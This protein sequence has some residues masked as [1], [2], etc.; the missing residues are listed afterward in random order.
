MSKSLYVSA[1]IPC[2]Q[3]PI[4]ITWVK[5]AVRIFCAK[6]LKDLCDKEFL[7]TPMTKVFQEPCASL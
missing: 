5:E 4:C 2:V 6:V 3:L 1:N 7:I